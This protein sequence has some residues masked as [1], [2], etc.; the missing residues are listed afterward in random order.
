MALRLMMVRPVTHL[1][2]AL[3]S[4]TPV[5]GAAHTILELL[6]PSTRVFMEEPA[7]VRNQGERWWNKVEQRHDRS[8]IGNLIRPGDG[9]LFDLPIAQYYAKKSI[10]TPNPPD[11]KF[12]VFTVA[13]PKAEEERDT[14]AN[15]AGGGEP[16]A[17]PAAP[18]QGPGRGANARREPRTGF[19]IMT[20]PDGQVK[21][22]DKVG[23]FRIP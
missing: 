17:E 15:A 19:G 22:F 8:G 7:M 3:M 12:V 16:S 2:L 21:T 11:V 1:I 9:V 4:V 13:Q 14:E 10:V 6:G 18:G 5:A 23:S 20:L